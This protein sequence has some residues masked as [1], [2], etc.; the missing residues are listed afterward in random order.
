MLGFNS[1]PVIGYPDRI[2]SIIDD[3]N[4]ESVRK[5]HGIA[6]HHLSEA[7]KILK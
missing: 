4:K 5:E 7:I 3:L 1:K 2:Q 6:L